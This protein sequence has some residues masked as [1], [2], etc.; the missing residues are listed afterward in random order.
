[1]VSM[2]FIGDFDSEESCLRTRKDRATA[3]KV[4]ARLLATLSA[5]QGRGDISG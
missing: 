2:H 3:G 5:W 4:A 1:M